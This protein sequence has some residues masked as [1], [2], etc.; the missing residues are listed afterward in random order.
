M[1]VSSSQPHYS[2][3]RD[4]LKISGWN[5]L[6]ID[7]FIGQNPRIWLQA[8]QMPVFDAVS[9]IECFCSYQRH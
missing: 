5:D 6:E 9:H 3:V 4:G 8:L 7:V 2:A 1:F